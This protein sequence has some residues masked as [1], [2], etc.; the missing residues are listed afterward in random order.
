VKLKL[1]ENLPLSISIRLAAIGLDTDTVLTEGLGGRPDAEVW[2]AAQIAQRF[3]VT[4][5]LDFSDVRRFA[6]GTHHG[7]L[8]VRLP[9]S[10]Q[11][12]IGD[13]LLGWFSTPEA[14]S[15][16]KCFVVATVNKVRVLRPAST[17]EP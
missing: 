16:E 14:R 7:I 5:D 13:Y 4:Q 2:Q 10:E 1:D 3:L 9:D 15:W 8:L 6:P 17:T 12:R 11:W